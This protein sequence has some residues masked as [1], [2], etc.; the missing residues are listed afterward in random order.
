MESCLKAEIS[1]RLATYKPLH[2]HIVFFEYFFHN[3]NH[4][5]KMLLKK[6]YINRIAF[7]K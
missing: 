3:S 6:R 7:T 5:E 4:I 1:L 2:T